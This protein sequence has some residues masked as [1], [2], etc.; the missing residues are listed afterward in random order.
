M[1]GLPSV[2]RTRQFTIQFMVMI[3]YLL[4]FKSITKANEI[5]VEDIE[6]QHKVPIVREKHA[7]VRTDDEST[8]RATGFSKDDNKFIRFKATFSPDSCDANAT[9]LL[10]QAVESNSEQYRFHLL[11][12]WESN[13]SNMDLLISLKDFNYGDK[14]T[15]YVCAKWTNDMDFVHMGTHSKFER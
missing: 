5:H 13:R 4:C 3:L 12:G 14:T 8:L 6:H 10:V 7:V 15:A 11:T 2:I 1:A 9:E